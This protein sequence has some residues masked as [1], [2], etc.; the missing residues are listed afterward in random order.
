MPPI[1]LTVF[2][3]GLAV[4]PARAAPASAPAGPADEKVWYL[5]VDGAQSGPFTAAEIQGQIKSGKLK[6]TALAWRDGQAAWLPLAENPTFAPMFA[7]P[8]QLPAP[9]PAAAPPPLP[10]ADPPPNADKPAGPAR[11]QMKRK[12]EAAYADQL[13]AEETMQRALIGVAVVLAGQ[14]LL[15]AVIVTVFFVINPGIGVIALVAAPVGLCLEC[16]GGL[17]VVGF[18]YKEK[19]DADAELQKVQSEAG[20]MRY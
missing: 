19:L 3:V 20:A 11:E 13:A 14:I 5:G 10:P 6:P 15:D 12:L 16:V 7:G 1:A 4:A 9:P 8:P 17:A 2:A 18:T